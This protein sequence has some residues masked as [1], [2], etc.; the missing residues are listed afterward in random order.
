MINL[1]KI[2]KTINTEPLTKAIWQTGKG[3]RKLNY[4]GK[5]FV[6]YFK[7]DEWNL[8]E[9]GES[10]LSYEPLLN[11]VSEDKK[12]IVSYKPNQIKSECPYI[13]IKGTEF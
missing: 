12:F 13:I 6:W 7:E 3:Q 2:G 10:F 11:I 1:R 8:V 4:N 5:I 9:N